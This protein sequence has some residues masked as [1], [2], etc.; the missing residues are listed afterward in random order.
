MED[1]MKVYHGTH[2][3][4]LP[5][6]QQ[7]G[8]RPNTFVTTDLYTAYHFATNSSNPSPV[9]ILKCTVSPKHLVWA[10]WNGTPK[11]SYM[12]SDVEE[13]L[14]DRYDVY[15][16]HTASIPPK[17]IIVMNPDSVHQHI[18]KLQDSWRQ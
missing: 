9:A 17:N 12:S 5:T 15:L 11:R 7:D 14:R 4:H 2:I 18:Q 3:N 8:L 16:M 13:R 1:K 6:I 10:D